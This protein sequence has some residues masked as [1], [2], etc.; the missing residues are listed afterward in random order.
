M[1]RYVATMTADR[2]EALE[3]EIAQAKARMRLQE[4]RRAK[5]AEEYEGNLAQALERQ[6]QVE[7]SSIFL[8]TSRLSATRTKLLDL[9]P[10]KV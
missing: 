4:A 5:E 1:A 9:D 10:N 8:R 2:Q 3:V 6:W 7:R